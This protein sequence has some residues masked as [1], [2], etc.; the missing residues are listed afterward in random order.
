L[1]AVACIG[2]PPLC[3]VAINDLS[4]AKNNHGGIDGMCLKGQFRFVQFQQHSDA[5]HL[6]LIQKFAIVLCQ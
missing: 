6:S 5:A 2:E 3:C 1:L 4:A